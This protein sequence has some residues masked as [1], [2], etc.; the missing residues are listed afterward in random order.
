MGNDSRSDAVV[1]RDAFGDAIRFTYRHSLTLVGVSLAWF[2]AVLPVVTFGPATVG[3]YRAVVGL[4][5]RGSVDVR[6][7]LATVRRQIVHSV[8]LG[9]L[10]LAFWGVST[11]YAIQYSLTNETITLVLFLGA[12]YIGTYLAMVAIPAFVA[13]A[14]GE[15]GYEAIS[16]GYSWL[17]EHV[18]LG[19]MTVVVTAIVAL[20]LSLLTIAFP[21]FFG[22]VAA[23]FHVEAV[24]DAYSERTVDDDEPTSATGSDETEPAI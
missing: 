24:D 2:I 5:E 13:L 15:P 4:R 21:A 3:A 11:F 9:L 19:L 7:V 12:F 6:A 1:L 18:T 16:F 20:V 17:R 22:G 10:P 14:H 8:L 23:T